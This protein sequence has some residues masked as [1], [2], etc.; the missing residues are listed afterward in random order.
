MHRA[1]GRAP[2]AALALA[3]AAAATC[4]L[5]ATT[6]GA[7]DREQ[8]TVLISRALDGGIPNG[9]STHAVISNDKRYSRAIA[10]QSD[11]SNLVNN[12]TNG[13]SD[14]FAVLRAG[15]INNK[16][17][18]WQPGRTVPISRTRSGAP[19]NGPSWAPAIDGGFHSAPKCVAF[20]SSASNLVGGD[21]NGVD[22]A[23]VT[24]LSGGAPKRV[25]RPGGK[26]SKAATTAVA[27]SGNCKLVAFVT[28]GKLYV[29]KN[30][31]KATRVKAPGVAAD[32]S[33][34]TGLR[35]DLVFGAKRGVYLKKDGKRRA[36][37]V[38]PGGRNP[39]YNDIKR[40]VVT[41][42]KSVGSYTQIGYK[43]LGHAERIISAHSGNAGNGSSRDPVIGNAGYYV[44]FESD[45]SNLGLNALSRTG[46]DNGEPD[47]YL[48]TDVRKLTLVQSVVEKAVPL[49]GGGQHPSMSFYANYVTFDAVPPHGRLGNDVI[50][51]VSG[52]GTPTLPAQQ[53][54]PQVFMRWLGGL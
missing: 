43:D 27:V 36:R 20:L 11:A 13:V 53:Q 2:R 38:A 50:G 42:E 19:A 44:T 1:R 47:V 37:L 12:D 49:A 10:F 28:G 54:P 21:T 7:A 33:F 32:P 48:Y 3:A 24:R 8:N 35:S 15:S 39:A 4:A 31:R 22:D 45:A 29:S 6:A 52:L 40:Q 23:F 41:Y 16:G 14:V 25:S 51:L 34:S 17:T 18:E 9:A 26:Q 46:D 5:G 30:G